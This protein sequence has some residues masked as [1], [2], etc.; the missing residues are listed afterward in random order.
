MA[1]SPK[2]YRYIDFDMVDNKNIRVVD[3]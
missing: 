2:L 3:K 1:L